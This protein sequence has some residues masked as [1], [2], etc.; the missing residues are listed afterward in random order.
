MS[1]R[2]VDASEGYNYMIKYST[3][4]HEI[5]AAIVLF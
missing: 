3:P 5:L 4:Q 2:I 1:K